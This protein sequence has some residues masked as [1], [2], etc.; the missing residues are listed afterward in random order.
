MHFGNTQAER[1]A[2]SAG[3]V[4]NG[5]FK[6]VGVS[7]LGRKCAELAGENAKIGVVDVTIQNVGDIIAVLLFADRICDYSERV[8]IVCSI[9]LQSVGLRDAFPRLNLFGNWPEVLWNEPVIHRY[10]PLKTFAE[11]PCTERSPVA[12]KDIE[13]GDPANFRLVRDKRFF[14]LNTPI[15]AYPKRPRLVTRPHD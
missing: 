3:N 9:K 8:E 1:R 10:S 15:D 14:E 13:T 5:S 4:V 7:L 6:S 2:D 12:T 11:Q